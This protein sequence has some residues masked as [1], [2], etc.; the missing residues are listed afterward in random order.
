MDCF[1]IQA[2]SQTISVV[3][4]SEHIITNSHSNNAGKARLLVS[5]ASHSGKWLHALPLSACDLHNADN[6]LRL[7]ATV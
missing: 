6:G 3:I 4:K 2:K 5:R 7:G 1:V